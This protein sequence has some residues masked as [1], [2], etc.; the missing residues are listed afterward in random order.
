MKYPK[1]N[2]LWK[3]DMANKGAIVEGDYSK[4]E[5]ENI[6]NWHFTE[7][8]DGTNIRIIFKKELEI[9]AGVS[10]GDQKLKTT[11][12]F[13]GRTDN[14]QLYP[15][16]LDYLKEQF[17]SELFERVFEIEDTQLY[18]LKKETE[19]ILF[20]E[21]YGAKI[22]KGG[23]DYRADVGFILFDIWVDGW[24]LQRK[25]VVEIAEKM[26]IDVVPEIKIGIGEINI[27]TIKDA[28]TFIK[29][30]PNSQIAE[31]DKVME[32]IVARSDPLMLFRNGDPIMWKLKV[33][34]YE[35]L[36]KIKRTE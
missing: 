33:K 30:I 31:K 7:K 23:G 2:T 5:F 25:A 32:G 28:L 24:W 18:G 20:G 13:G 35:Q 10:V 8:I 21:G 26:G 11:L 12:K 15:K 6:I 34:D 36:I 22:Q 17:D 29:S 1:I 3:R 14:A 16:L 4:E 27:H 19:I 9:L